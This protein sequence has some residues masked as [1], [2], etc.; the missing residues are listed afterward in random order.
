MGF[1][2]CTA[3]LASTSEPSPMEARLWSTAGVVTTAEESE[4]GA[5]GVLQLPFLDEIRWTADLG[6]FR[7]IDFAPVPG[8]EGF[9]GAE[10]LRSIDDGLASWRVGMDHLAWRG[11]PPELVLQQVA[12]RPLLEG[13]IELAAPEPALGFVSAKT[14]VVGVLQDCALL[15][16]EATPFALGAGPKE[17]CFTWDLHSPLDPRESWV[18]LQV[19]GPHQPPPIRV[20][21]SPFDAPVALT[22]ERLVVDETSDRFEVQVESRRGP[23]RVQ[24]IDCPPS[25]ELVEVERVA[26]ERQV[27][28]LTRSPSS[29]ERH[30]SATLMIEFAIGDDPE[31]YYRTVQVESREP[32]RDADDVLVLSAVLAVGESVQLNED[33]EGNLELAYPSRFPTRASVSSSGSSFVCQEATQGSAVLLEG[34]RGPVRL[35]YRTEESLYGLM[36]GWMD[37]LY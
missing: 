30:R 9:W 11:S 5:N 32:L 34:P 2:I 12:D 29:G 37:Q 3:L 16:G 23:I 24:A 6:S 33:S 13:C 15:G 1:L 17:L 19:D 18:A 8:N 14:S 27:V 36:E 26:P 20:R 21:A 35:R 25:L 4:G 7:E 22:P 28:R 10:P 31:P